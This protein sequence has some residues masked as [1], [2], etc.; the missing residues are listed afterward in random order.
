M[1]DHGIV[2]NRYI[3]LFPLDPG[4]VFRNL[5]KLRVEK[6]QRVI[7]LGLADAQDPSCETGV[8]KDALDPCDGVDSDDG[9]N[10]FD[11]LTSDVLT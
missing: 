3:I 9:V 1:V 5:S 6:L 8:D 7:A 2:P 4:R 11:P 10:R